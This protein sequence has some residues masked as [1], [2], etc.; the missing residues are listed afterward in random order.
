MCVPSSLTCG[1]CP[2]LITSLKMIVAAVL[3]S[4]FLAIQA[5]MP[6]KATETNSGVAKA[7]Y[8]IFFFPSLVCTRL[9]AIV[10]SPR[11]NSQLSESRV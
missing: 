8:W 11:G 2:V 3:V 4:P 7:F 6:N 10:L 5:L 9:L 1:Y